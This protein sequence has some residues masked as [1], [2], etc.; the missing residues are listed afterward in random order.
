MASAR[1]GKEDKD[2]RKEEKKN[3]DTLDRGGDERCKLQREKERD[4]D[5]ARERQGG[6]K[7]ERGREREGKSERERMM[8]MSGEER[9]E[10]PHTRICVRHTRGCSKV[11][12]W[13]LAVRQNQ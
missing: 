9:W 7:G 4:R 2:N 10:C 11:F 6:R 1:G 5:R 8:M 13:H 12:F 3:P